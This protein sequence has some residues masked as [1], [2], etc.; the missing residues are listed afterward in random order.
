MSTKGLNLND[1]YK[2]NFNTNISSKK[3]INRSG[4]DKQGNKFQID[5]KDTPYSLKNRD[6]ESSNSNK[7]INNYCDINIELKDSKDSKKRIIKNNRFSRAG[8]NKIRSANV[9]EDNSRNQPVQLR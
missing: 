2:N 1:A 8:R 6:I 9:N 7:F 3:Q 4:S 5:Y